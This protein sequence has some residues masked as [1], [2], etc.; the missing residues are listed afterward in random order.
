MTYKMFKQEGYEGYVV[1]RYPTQEDDFFQK[2]LA[3]RADLKL[4]LWKKIKDGGEDSEASRKAFAELYT[5]FLE[6]EI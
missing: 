2:I 1:D 4:L 3:G 5:K 6:Q